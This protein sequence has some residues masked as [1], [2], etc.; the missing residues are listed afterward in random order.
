MFFAAASNPVH[1]VANPDKSRVLFYFIKIKNDSKD[2]Y[3]VAKYFYF[4]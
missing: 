3:N 1:I 2:I 4:R